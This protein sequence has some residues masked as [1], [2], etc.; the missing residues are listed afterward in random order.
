MSDKNEFMKAMNERAV[1]QD[2]AMSAE[3][4]RK[5]CETCVFV[6]LHPNCSRCSTVSRFENEWKYGKFKKFVEDESKDIAERRNVA[7]NYAH[8]MS[9]DEDLLIK[10]S[11]MGTGIL[12]AMKDYENQ[13][14][15]LKKELEKK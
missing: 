15:I 12:R 11:A 4:A 2:V 8:A 7:F 10:H 6:N 9:K 13:I 5:V 3:A 1:D 14:V